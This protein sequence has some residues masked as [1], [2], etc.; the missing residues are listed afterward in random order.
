MHAEGVCGAGLSHLYG[1]R[2]GGW[3]RE[4]ERGT[5]QVVL[6]VQSRMFQKYLENLSR[7]ERNRR[8]AGKIKWS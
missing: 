3:R 7:E 8:E 6:Q 4:M 1:K 2:D 5:E